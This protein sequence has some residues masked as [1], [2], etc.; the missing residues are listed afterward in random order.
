MIEIP[1]EQ[2][3]GSD[4][5]TGDIPYRL[6]LKATDTFLTGTASSQFHSFARKDQF[7]ARGVAASIF[8]VME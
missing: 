1:S 7:C 8:D 2:H 4:W 5:P 6:D 3:G